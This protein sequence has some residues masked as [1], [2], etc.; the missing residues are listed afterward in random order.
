M[1]VYGKLYKFDLVIFDEPSDLSVPRLSSNHAQAIQGSPH[2]H[3]PR[4]PFPNSTLA[5]NAARRSSPVL[6]PGR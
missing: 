3:F 6:D 1:T 5:Y 4:P 2:R